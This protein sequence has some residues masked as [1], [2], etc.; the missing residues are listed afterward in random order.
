M[1]TNYIKSDLFSKFP[2]IEHGFGNAHAV[3]PVDI[4]LMPQ[5]HTNNVVIVDELPVNYI[6]VADAMLTHVHSVMLGV[7]TADC[8]PILLYN[9]KI[10]IVGV[11]HAGWRGLANKVIFNAVEKLCTFYNAR[12]EDTYFAI[13]PGICK[14]CYEVSMEVFDSIN[15]IINVKTAFRKTSKN[16]GL[17]DL[18]SIAHK[19]L[20]AAGIPGANISN[21]NMCTKCSKGFHSHR[22]GSKERQ[23]SYIKIL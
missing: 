3:W 12:E 13:G 11:I 22:A 15:S 14:K 19:E 23:V 17:L 9:P 7:K 20:E 4:I 6:P 16:K 1:N 21:I 5:K 2:E 8:L 10:R 18:S